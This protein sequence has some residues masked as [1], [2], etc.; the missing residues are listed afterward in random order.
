MAPPRRPHTIVPDQVLTVESD[1]LNLMSDQQ[2]IEFAA[3]HL[4]LVFAPG[5][6]RTL[7][8]SKIVSSSLVIADA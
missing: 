5:T 8:L 1:D 6:P 4:S 7:V 2:L 3:Q